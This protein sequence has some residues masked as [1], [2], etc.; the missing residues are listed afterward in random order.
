MNNCL[1]FKLQ[2]CFQA[3]KGSC[4]DMIYLALYIIGNPEC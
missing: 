2:N 3:T 4:D 1:A